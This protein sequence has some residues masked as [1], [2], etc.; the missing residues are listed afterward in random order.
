MVSGTTTALP[1]ESK[2]LE[3]EWSG[4]RYWVRIIKQ[5][6]EAIASQVPAGYED[7]TGFHY[8][9]AEPQPLLIRTG[10]NP[11]RSSRQSFLMRG[12]DNAA[13]GF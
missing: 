4:A 6:C 3:I 13:V 2:A 5:A 1:F 11:N 9:V 12:G 7:A 10:R 8:G